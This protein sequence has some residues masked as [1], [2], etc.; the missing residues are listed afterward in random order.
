MLS[1]FEDSKFVDEI[2][3]KAK[4]I[5]DEISKFKNVEKLTGLGLMI[6]I[7]VKDKK[8]KDVRAAC[9]KDCLL[10]LTAKDNVR[11]LP[12]LNIT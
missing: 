8:G 2:N 5:R 7:K 4:Y 9:E 1:K 10:I 12:P 11:L 3:A 6:G